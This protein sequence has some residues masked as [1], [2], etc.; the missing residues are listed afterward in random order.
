M[1]SL[2]FSGNQCITSSLTF[3]SDQLEVWKSMAFKEKETTATTA[4]LED[5]WPKPDEQ[6]YRRLKLNS[7]AKTLCP[8]NFLIIGYT[9]VSGFVPVPKH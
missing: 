3:E 4:I 7:K 6:I 2:H 5:S 8:Q 1:I 9:Q